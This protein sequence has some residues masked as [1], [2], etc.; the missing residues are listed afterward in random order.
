MT[1]TIDRLIAYIPNVIGAAL[2]VLLGLLVARFVASLVSSA[3]A[4][5]GFPSAQRMGF[6]AQMTVTALVAVPPT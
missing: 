2:I 6:L 5:A 3:A 1:S 4:A